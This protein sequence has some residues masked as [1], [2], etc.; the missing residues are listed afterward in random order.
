[1]GNRGRSPKPPKNSDSPLQEGFQ[2]ASLKAP[3]IPRSK[4]RLTES[5][6]GLRRSMFQQYRVPN[7]LIYRPGCLDGES[8][9]NGRFNDRFCRRDAVVIVTLH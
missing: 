6:V 8:K 2:N 3:L 7:N 1:M 9:H 4:P 5:A